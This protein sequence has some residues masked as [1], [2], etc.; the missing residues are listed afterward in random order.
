MHDGSRDRVIAIVQPS[1]GFKVV[2]TGELQD[3]RHGE[4][5]VKLMQKGI[6]EARIVAQVRRDREIRYGNFAISFPA[7]AA[8]FRF[9]AASASIGAGLGV[10]GL[11]I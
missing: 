7:A 3:L 1:L 9:V 8:P 10:F 11:I 2:P 5:A 6:R 4:S